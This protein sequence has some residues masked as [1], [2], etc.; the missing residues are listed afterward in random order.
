MGLVWPAFGLL[1]AAT[2]TGSPHK[3]GTG[4][5]WVLT[6]SSHDLKR[7]YCVANPTYAVALGEA[8]RKHQ[9]VIHREAGIL[10]P[11]S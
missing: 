6:A 3:T 5:F 8:P 9:L 11:L 1:V 7:F 4:S 2:W 10:G